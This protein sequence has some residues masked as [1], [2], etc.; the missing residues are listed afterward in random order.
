ML[1]KG[2]RLVYSTCSFNPIEDEAVVCA[3]LQK[4]IK[5]VEL[6]DVSG[7]ISK[8]LIYRPG[9]TS[10]RVYYRPNKE[11]EALWFT[12]YEDVP[13]KRRKTIKET[14]FSDAYTVYN[15]DPDTKGK[16]SDPLNL[17]RCM[18]FFPHD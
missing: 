4:Y 15:N 13:Q 9:L 17:R 10:W 6:V 18:R 1:K 5:Q 8:D 7:E 16:M 12:R 2:G 11:K 14:M 3:A